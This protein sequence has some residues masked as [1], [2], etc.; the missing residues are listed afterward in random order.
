MRTETSDVDPVST[1][2]EEGVF[3][4]FDA[5]AGVWA[6]EALRSLTCRSGG[7]CVSNLEQKKV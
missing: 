1:P 4:R 2:V 7:G 5:M 3:V 6:G